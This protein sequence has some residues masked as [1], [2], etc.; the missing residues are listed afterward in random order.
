M[1]AGACSKLPSNARPPVSARQPARDHAVEVY[2]GER[3]RADLDLATAVFREP[4]VVRIHGTTVGEVRNL[5]VPHEVDAAARHS[6]FSRY[7][8][9]EMRSF[10]AT[11]SF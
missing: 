5:P 7:A 6:Y 9:F 1:Q 8:G 3:L 11:C 2:V 4:H 10:A